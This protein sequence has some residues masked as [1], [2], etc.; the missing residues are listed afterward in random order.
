MKIL[1]VCHYGHSRSAAL[2]RMLHHHK[3]DAIDTFMEG[4][5]E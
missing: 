2:V 5:K 1:C 4:E 3:H